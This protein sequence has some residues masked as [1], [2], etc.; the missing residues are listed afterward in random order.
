MTLCPFETSVTIHKPTW[1][2]FPDD[3]SLQELLINNSVS[4]EDKINVATRIS[5]SASVSNLH[6]TLLHVSV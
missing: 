5:L 3:F 4:Y 6:Y 1:R 2:N